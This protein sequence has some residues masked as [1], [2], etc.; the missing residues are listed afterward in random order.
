M[1]KIDLTNYLD[2]HVD[3]R[4]EVAAS[5]AACEYYPLLLH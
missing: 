5:L 4:S 2:R 1:L 3:F